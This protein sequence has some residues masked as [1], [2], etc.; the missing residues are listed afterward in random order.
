MNDISFASAFER[1]FGAQMLDVH[2]M[3]PA[4]V[5]EYEGHV[6]RKVRITPQVKFTAPSGITTDYP[7]IAGV[8]VLFP[9]TPRFSF[10]FDLKPG[11]TGLVLF[12]EAALGNWLNSQ[13]ATEPLEPEDATRFS[14]TDAI[15]IPGLFPYADVPQ[16]NAPSNGAYIGY[17]GSSIILN[18]DGTMSLSDKN[19]NTIATTAT[20]VRINGNFE[21]LQ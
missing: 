20:S 1:W 2:T 7:P 18:E 12:S 15:F 3:L 21:V 11:D 19:G 9:S 17:E 10:L 8:P 5:E 6:S 14:M 13:N 16:I 4:K